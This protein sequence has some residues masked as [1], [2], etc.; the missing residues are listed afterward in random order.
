MQLNKLWLALILMYLLYQ[1]KHRD[2]SLSCWM[3]GTLSKKPRVL[4]GTV[5]NNKS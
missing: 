3:T 4:H 5:K 1:V 2:A